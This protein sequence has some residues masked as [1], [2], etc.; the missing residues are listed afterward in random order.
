MADTSVNTYEGLFLFPH[1]VS[2]NLQAAV[3]HLTELLDRAGAEVLS[4]RKWDERKLAY[5]IKGNKR[6]VYFLVYFKAAT[7][8]LQGL[9]R[10]CNLSE[11]LLRAMMIRADHVPADQISAADA[12][13][14]L[15]DEI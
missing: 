14:E 4:L 11:Q 2:G 12:R 15:A 10:D 6:G 13:Q 9:D 7:D 8:R 1:S 3:D 5:E